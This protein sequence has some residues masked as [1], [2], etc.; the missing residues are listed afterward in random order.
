[1]RIKQT[2]RKLLATAFA[3]M[4]CWSMW[5]QETYNPVANPDAVVE[6][7]RMRFTVLTPQMIRIQYSSKQLFEDRATFA[8]VNRNLPVPTFTVE[9]KD[10]YLYIKTD[11]L[12]L[13]Y[14][15]GTIPTP[16]TKNSTRLNIKFNL[17]GR[18]VIW[19][20]GKDDALNLKGTLRTLD[21][22]TGDSNRGDLENGILSRDGWAVI[23][24][25]PAARRGDGSTTFAFDKEVNG[26]PWAAKPVDESAYDWYFLGYG[27]EYKKALGDFI[28][29]AGRIPMPPLYVL[30]YWYSKYQQ[31]TQQD[32]INLVNE[33]QGNDI[34]I[35]VMIMDMDWHRSDQ[36]TG[37]S[38]DR[39][40]IP[41]PT[42]LI[43]W[44]HGKNLKVSLNLHPA[45]GVG[46]YE[47]NFAQIRD[48]MGMPESADRVPWTL[49]DS[50]FYKTMFKNIIRVRE[51]EGVDFWWLDWQQNLTNPRMEGLSETFWCNHVFYNDMKQNRP[52]VRP[53]IYHRWGGLG[54]HRYPIG[55]S[56]DTHPAFSTLAYETYFT[57]TASNVGFG[58]WGHDLGGHNYAPTNNNDPEL[59]LRWMQ[60][61][62]FTPIFRTHASNHPSLE[63]RIWKYPNFEFLR[64]T[65]YLR[66]ELMP[67]IYAA[68]REGYD[69]GVSMCRPL[70]YEHPEENNAY[71]YEDEYYFGNDIIVAPVVTAASG[72]GLAKRTTW[73]PEGKWYDVCR[74]RMID[75][76]IELTDSYSQTEIPY[77]IKAGSVIVNNPLIMT[78]ASVPEQLIIKVVPE[79]NG[80]TQLYEDEGDTDGYK[81]GIYSTTEISQKRGER[82]IV[83]TINPRVG[84]YPNMP[85]QRAYKVI[86]LAEEKPESVTLNGEEISEWTFDE[87]T[88]TLTVD[89][90]LT[91]C[92][93]KTV[94]EVM[95][96]YLNVQPT[97]AGTIDMFFDSADETVRVSTSE[98][99]AQ[100]SLHVY[101]MDG[102]EVV[103]ADMSGKESLAVS[104]SGMP[105]GAYVCRLVADGTVLT[106]KFAK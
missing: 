49:E 79:G 1:M 52:D 53:L 94:V 91:S 23:D 35:D 15:T 29:V 77:F 7:G 26:I 89:I 104:L 55:F 85:E 84:A 81:S 72:N 4:A 92:D 31:Y 99:V 2:L 56:G 95:S 102:T 101:N 78:L 36:W 22:V 39:N 69:T 105:S 38:W 43:R 47:D 41:N 34:P 76:G 68:A 50:T 88:K 16:E 21:Q 32:F 54:S 27:H 18:E 82:K 61:G 86:F 20:P 14:K 62:V 33:I 57:A 37:W 30:G 64:E 48:D 3:F 60:F 13:T 106:R 74:N 71:R 93:A 100:G 83:L 70:Y 90:P 9:E 24:E 97:F 12:T 5:A 96:N 25:S 17:N 67:Y 8:I 44:M 80:T 19:Y 11:A 66:Y 59:Y 75:G 42:G 46:S 45:D 10:G 6:S 65:V 58:Y 28:K 73:L 87:L 98:T 103:S 40:K 63:R 51:K